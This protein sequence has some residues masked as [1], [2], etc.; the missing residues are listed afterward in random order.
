MTKI[1]ALD[2]YRQPHEV[3]IAKV[4][5]PRAGVYGIVIRDKKILLL[6]DKTCELYA[7]PGGTVKVGEDFGDT[8]VREIKE[9]T[10][11]SI[12]TGKLVDIKTNIFFQP[13]NRP[14]RQTLQIYFTAEYLSGEISNDGF[15]QWEKDC[16]GLA[17]WID[18]SKIDTVKFGTSI[19][20]LPIIKKALNEKMREEVL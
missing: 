19:D 9:E 12:Q 16:L 6:P 14:V 8:L 2:M 11:I 4:E 20:I 7:L 3:D 18:I 5:P 1:V 17:E 13:E 15:D 10:G